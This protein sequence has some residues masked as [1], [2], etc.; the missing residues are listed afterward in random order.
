M[1]KGLIYLGIILL[2][3]GC[4]NQAVDHTESAEE[5]TPLDEIITS[6]EDVS[7]SNLDSMWYFIEEADALLNSDREKYA[8]DVGKVDFLKAQYYDLKSDDARAK[9]YLAKAEMEADEVR[10]FATLVDIYDYLGTKHFI[11]RE[12]AEAIENYHLLQKYARLDG[13]EKKVNIAE[14][15]I[16]TVYQAE[17]NIKK[18]L[19]TYYKLI[20]YF[21]K[22]KDYYGLSVLFGN[23]GGLHIKLD[24]YSDAL[25][26]SN[27]AIAA[28]KKSGR[29]E[30]RNLVLLYTN[31]GT[32]LSDLNKPNEAILSYKK[33]LELSEKLEL[34]Q[35]I[36]IRYL[37]AEQYA[38]LDSNAKAQ[39][40]FQSAL[41]EAIDADDKYYM[42]EASK[43]YGMYLYTHGNKRQG[44]SLLENSIK[45]SKELEGNH[46]TYEIYKVMSEYYAENHNYEKA[47]K[48]YIA[49]REQKDSIINKENLLLS[50]TEKLNYEH[51]L[52]MKEA[53]LMAEKKKKEYLQRI[54]LA[55][56]LLLLASSFGFLFW[57]RYKQKR[58]REVIILDKNRKLES[59]NKIIR[60]AIKD[61]KQANNDL[62]SFAYATAH[63]IKNP[64]NT[65]G[66]FLHLIAHD[67][68]NK[69][70]KDSREHI[71]SI[72]K[73]ISRLIELLE[74]ILNYASVN[75]QAIELQTVDLNQKLDQVKLMLM[76]Q[77]VDNDAEILIESNLPAV[78]AEPLLVYQLLLN[79]IS[80]G[81]KYHRKNARPI[82]TITGEDLGEYYKI[83]ISDNGIGIP[84]DE[85]KNIFELFVR[86][87]NSKEYEGTGV[88]L[89]VSKRI[90]Q[91][92]DGKI[93]VKN[94]QSNHG[95]TFEIYFRKE[96]NATL[97]QQAMISESNLTENES[98]SH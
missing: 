57:Y 37:L 6:A 41:N 52:Q 92:L 60:K 22:E 58:K 78:M 84:E 46:D 32:S 25:E 67:E 50:K 29:P 51:G 9:E 93:A 3:S 83:N 98:A 18:A 8:N 70:T 34:S 91:L 4:D 43:L 45:Y 61:L 63:D 66:G 33:A 88:G 77:I 76:S 53:E 65:I 87:R 17:G 30:D 38:K 54:Y 7:S 44:V 55:L 59:K 94:N 86:A 80:N 64:I 13:D 21:E 97:H 16:A 62:E 2:F 79:L 49:Y 27:E 48:D 19:S 90:M 96:V 82:I 47:Y 95:A 42:Y 20:P 26:A 69:L 10:D 23:I 71:E 40:E 12:Y 85:L 89:A 56:S 24:E 5:S 11:K 35:S 14:L 75:R 31:K 36:K 28:F 39:K 72:D 68:G 81:I 1:K 74:S 73:S 15:N